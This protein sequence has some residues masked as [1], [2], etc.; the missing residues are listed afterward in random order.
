MVSRTSR[1]SKEEIRQFVLHKLRVR[2]PGLELRPICSALRASAAMIRGPSSSRWWPRC[3]A[4]SGVLGPRAA[5][6]SAVIPRRHDAVDEGPAAGRSEGT[7]PRAE[8]SSGSLGAQS[9]SSRWAALLRR[10]F[11]LDVF[12]C[13]RCGG[14]SWGGPR[15]ASAGG[16]CSSGSGSGSPRHP[17][18]RRARRR[19]GQ[20][21][22]TRPSSR[23]SLAG[24]GPLA[25]VCLPSSFSLWP[26]PTSSLRGHGSRR[27]AALLSTAE[28]HRP[29]RTLDFA[30]R[31]TIVACGGKGERLAAANGLP[32]TSSSSSTSL[33]ERDAPRNRQARRVPHLGCATPL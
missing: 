9:E 6:R 20:R 30:L 14:G 27:I 26:L 29:A 15:G 32:S 19:D 11:A 17:R 33:P 25:V 28:G 2:V 12:Q 5:W 7:G 10:V 23:H 24:S 3:S 22:R 18:S 31:G 13:P 16:S 8:P 4:G 21:S 1:L